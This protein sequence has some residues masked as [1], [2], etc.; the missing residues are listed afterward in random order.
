[1]RKATTFV[2]TRII[3]RRQESLYLVNQLLIFTGIEEKA[4]EEGSSWVALAMTKL[5]NLLIKI[6]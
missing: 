6:L 1:L 4:K 2:M 5:K 3:L